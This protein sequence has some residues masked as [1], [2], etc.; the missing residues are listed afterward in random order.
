MNLDAKVGSYVVITFK[1]TGTGIAPEHID[2]IFEP[3]FTTKELGAG[4]GLGLSTTMGIIKNHGGF[5]TVSSEVGCETQFQVFLPAINVTAVAAAEIPEL[6]RGQGEL[7]LVVDD[8]VNIREMLKITLESYNYKVITA[9]D[10][11]DAIAVYAVNQDEVKAVLIDV[12]MPLMDGITAI[13][14]F[15]RFN[16][17]HQLKI[18]ACSGVVASNNLLTMTGVKAFLPKPFTTENLLI[19]LFRVLQED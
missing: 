12:M 6:P 2:R 18:I 16:F 13:K 14:A 3:F 9:C 10:G 8:E 5:V 11:V 19:T 4:T 15:Q 7:I 1:D 17:I